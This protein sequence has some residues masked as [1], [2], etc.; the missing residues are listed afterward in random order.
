MRPRRIYV[1]ADLER[2]FADYLTHMACRATEFGLPLTGQHPLL[3][4]LQRPPLMSALREGTVR[5]ETRAFR[6]RGVGPR[7]WTPHWFRHTHATALLLAGTPEWV[8]SR[9]FGHAPAMRPA[10]PVVAA[11]TAGQLRRFAGKPHPPLA[12]VGRQVAPGHDA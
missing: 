4:N 2:L 10:D 1:G 3:V 5:D 12:A 11:R 9:R 6:A 7:D 8:V